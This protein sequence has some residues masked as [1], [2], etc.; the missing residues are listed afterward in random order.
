MIKYN[1]NFYIIVVNNMKIVSIYNNYLN[2]YIISVF[3]LPIQKNNK[4][5]WLI[6]LYSL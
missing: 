3:V 4:S 5:I 6:Y 1:L 2:K